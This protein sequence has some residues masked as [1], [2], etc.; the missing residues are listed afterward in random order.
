MKN[1]RSTV[2]LSLL[3]TALL[4]VTGVSKS[5]AADSGNPV[6]HPPRLTE[7]KDIQKSFAMLSKVLKPV[8]ESATLTLF[9]GLPHQAW[10][11]PALET[12]LASK[13]TIQRF[14]FP[15]YRK[16]VQVT[17]ADTKKLLSIIQA[18][19]AFK[20]FRGFKGC[21]GFHPDYSL[22]WTDGN[23]TSEIHLCFGCDEIKAYHNDI[24]VYCE[25]GEKTQNEFIHLLK[26][27]RVQRPGKEE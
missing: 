14:G 9:E 13:D 17:E 19:G 1:S 25:M 10:E 7:K 15:F 5:A 22:T 6:G 16:P 20:E 4:S 21:G 18:P 2:S 23:E 12:E 24:E 11:A 26:K 27:Y 3:A 8:S